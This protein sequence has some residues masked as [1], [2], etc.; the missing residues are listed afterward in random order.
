M[1]FIHG[2]AFAFESTSDP[3]YQGSNFAA[4]NDV[5]LVS[6]EYRMNV[7]GFMNLASVDSAFED[8]GYLGMK[9]QVA[10]LQ[11]VKDNIAEFGGNPDNITIFGESAG[12]IAVMLL[13]V[14]SAANGLFDKAI[15]QSGHVDFYHKPENSAQLAEQFM[16]ISGAKTVGNLLKKSTDELKAIYL[17]FSEVRGLS[18]GDYFPTCDG[19]FLPRDPFKALKDGAARGIKLLTGT[20]ADEWRCFLLADENLFKFFRAEPEKNSPILSRYKA[21]TNEEIYRDWLNG[22]PDTDDTY[23]DFATQIDWRVGQELTAE[24]QSKFND[25]YYYLF[26]EWSPIEILRSCH[27]VDLPFT[28]NNGE[29]LYPNPPQNLVKQVQTTWT[30]FATTGNPNNETIPRWE[31]YTVGNRQTMELN[32]KGCVC[33]KDLNT[34]NLNALRYVYED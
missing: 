11:W 23:G 8:S 24:Y 15:P 7:F 1:V 18:L 14:T 13:T 22:R 25:V 19:K 32:S 20:T 28:F 9:D 4:A 30:A 5:V 33:H 29:I 21:R 6:L 26:S 27:A 12:S 16:A 31:K 3:L 34:E 10:G 2:G 17:K